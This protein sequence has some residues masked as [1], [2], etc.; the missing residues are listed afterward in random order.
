MSR[1]QFDDSIRQALR[2]GKDSRWDPD[3]VAVYAEFQHRCQSGG[4]VREAHQQPAVRRGRWTA[5]LLSAAA[6]AA[7]ILVVNVSVTSY[8]SATSASKSLPSVPAAQAPAVGESPVPAAPAPGPSK[9][10][11]SDGSEE[12]V[13]TPEG[14]CGSGYRVIDQRTLTRSVVYLLWKPSTQQNCVVTLKTREIGGKTPVT[15]HV[16]ADGAPR[17]VDSG[18]FSYYA[19]PVRQKAPGCVSWGGSDDVGP[20]F[21][22][23]GHCSP[24]AAGSGN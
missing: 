1:E 15:A 13:Y 4:A 23:R 16:Q 24:G 3:V 2:D 7:A 10:D 11:D 14:V 22:A 8:R 6:V 5:G 18:N 21:S 9:E 17:L 12:S 20:G 19:G